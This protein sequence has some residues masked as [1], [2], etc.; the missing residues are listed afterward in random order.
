MS[1]RKE[2]V[3]RVIEA[4]AAGEVYSSIAKREGISRSAVSGI[5]SRERERTGAKPMTPR[6][7]NRRIPRPK[8]TL[9][10]K[11]TGPSLG[12]WK[13]AALAP[14]AA[15]KPRVDPTTPE[16]LAAA[17]LIAQAKRKEAANRAAREVRTL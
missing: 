13:R 1:V 6:E 4:V 16:A 8:K 15:V 17:A 9:A 10:I 7:A 11:P 3:G 14:A 2:L 5:A 12:Q